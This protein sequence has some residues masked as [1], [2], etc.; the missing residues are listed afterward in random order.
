MNFFEKGVILESSDPGFGR[1]FVSN[2]G[3]LYDSNEDVIKGV[4]FGMTD[5]ETF[6]G[7]DIGFAYPQYKVDV[8]SCPSTWHI[9]RQSQHFHRSITETFGFTDFCRIRIVNPSN[10]TVIID[11]KV[12]SIPGDVWT[13]TGNPD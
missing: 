3:W 2:P 11:H 8:L 13:L 10:G 5:E 12:E 1:E 4:A 6:T 7:H 9:Y